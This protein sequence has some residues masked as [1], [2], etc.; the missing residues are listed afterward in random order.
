MPLDRITLPA[1]LPLHANALADHVRQDVGTDTEL[2]LGCLR[3]ARDFAEAR[4]NRTLIATRYKLTLDAFPQGGG[5][6]GTYAPFTLPPN[7]ILLERGPVLKLVSIKYLDMSGTQQLLA[8]TEYAVSLAGQL[9]RVT[10]AFGKVWPANTLPQ[11]GAVEVTFDAGD[12]TGITVDPASDTVS[13]TGGLWRTLTVGDALRFSNSGGVLPSPLVPDTDYYVQAL[14]TSTSFKLA[15]TAGGSVIDITA[16]GS[17]QSYL[18]VVPDGVCSWMKLRIGGLYENR[19]DAMVV[20]RGTLFEV[21]YMDNLLD[22]FRQ[23]LY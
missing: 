23:P 15:A 17:G 10:P 19:E 4:C 6:L 16:A 18:G 7:A 21:P 2:L 14:P 11:I 13:I 8:A 22:S 3:S 1:A 9:G 5:I 20:Q 12:A